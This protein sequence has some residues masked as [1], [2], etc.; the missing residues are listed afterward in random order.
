M[1]TAGV[2][3]GK[4]SEGRSFGGSLLRDIEREIE[5][6]RL[7]AT[8]VAAV[9]GMARRHLSGDRGRQGASE[10]RR[11]KTKPMADTWRDQKIQQNDF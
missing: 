1:A 2:R 4:V 5:A 7:A 11:R 10:R 9:H 6:G 8:T 3:R